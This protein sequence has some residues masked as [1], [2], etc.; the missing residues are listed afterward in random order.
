M[1]INVV[2][3][4][5]GIPSGML[6]GLLAFLFLSHPEINSL[7]HVWAFMS[8]ITVGVV[9]GVV[10]AL[11]VWWFWT[12]YMSP[13]INISEKIGKDEDKQRN[14]GCGFAYTIKWENARKRPMEDVRMEGNVFIP[15]LLG[16]V[17]NKIV[18]IPLSVDKILRFP[19]AS[20][21]IKPNRI[22]VLE[23]DDEDCVQEFSSGIYPD[24]LRDLAGRREL[25]LEAILRVEKNCRF[26]FYIRSVDSVS[27]TARV[28]WRQYYLE[29]IV[30]GR[31]EPRSVKMM[32]AED[33][34]DPMV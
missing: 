16:K 31:F 8:P 26:R 32:N 13:K 6:L 17:R 34:I 27:R 29:D 22:I 15:R 3:F 14:R 24:Y 1:N 2:S 30:R 19:P 7:R 12:H 11:A 20:S 18:P 4:V 33:G 10:S 5:V 9:S 23:L 21:R 25:S 28:F